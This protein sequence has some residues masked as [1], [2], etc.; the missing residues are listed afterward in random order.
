M[1]VMCQTSLA[2]SFLGLEGLRWGPPGSITVVLL[3]HQAVPTPSIL[4]FWASISPVLL[5]LFQGD[6]SH[7]DV[8][9]RDFFPEAQK[10]GEEHWWSRSLPCPGQ[11]WVSSGLGGGGHWQGPARPA[12]TLRLHWAQVY[13]VWGSKK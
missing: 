12:P 5:S 7:T 3:G 2:P 8:Y 11:P 4:G 1:L 10:D 6:F 13:Y 9:I